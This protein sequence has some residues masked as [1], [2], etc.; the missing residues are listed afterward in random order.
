MRRLLLLALAAGALVV[1]AQAQ[2]ADPDTDG[3]PEPGFYTVES[4]A[5]EV[6]PDGAPALADAAFSAEAG[7]CKRVWA[8]RVYRNLLGIPLWKYFQ[9]QAFCYNGSRITSLYDYRR[10]AEVYAPGWDFRRH[11]AR[12]TTGGAGTW[13]Y[14]TWTQGHFALCAAWCAQHKYPWVDIDVYGNGGWSHRTGGT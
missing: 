8:A 7:G 4:G 13:H 9:Q 5:V 14:G 10:W 3:A 1:P 6:S 11:I 2:A 12:S